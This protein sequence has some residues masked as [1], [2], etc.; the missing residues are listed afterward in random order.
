M[1]ACRC[2]FVTCFLSIGSMIATGYQG[3]PLTTDGCESNGRAT[4]W[5]NQD[6]PSSQLVRFR[7]ASVLRHSC[8]FGHLEFSGYGVSHSWRH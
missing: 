8:A 4:G 7:P 2:T 5:G 3:F 6:T 1:F